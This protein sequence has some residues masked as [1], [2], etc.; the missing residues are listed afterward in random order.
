MI[1]PQPQKQPTEP[2]AAQS[3]TS[4]WSDFDLYLFGQGKD[5]HVYEKFGAHARLVDGVAGVNFSVWAPHARSV[6]V[7]G[8]FNSWDRTANSMWRRHNDLGVWECFI[9]GLRMGEVYKYF[10]TSSLNDYQVEKADP[11]AFAAERPPRTASI[12]Y[13]IHQHQWQDQDWMQ[14]RPQY[15][16]LPTPVAIYELHAGSWRHILDE[17]GSRPMTYRELA[18]ALAPY[19]KEMGFTHVELMPI[20]EYPYDPSWG[21]Q[22]TGYF[23][24]TS[25][26][27]APE[28]FQYFVD[29]LHQQGIGVILDWVPAHFPKDQYG[30]G[31]FDGTHLYEYADPRKGEHKEWG[32]YVFDYGRSEVCNFL[33]ASAVFWLREYHIDGLR[34][35][36]VASML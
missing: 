3:A 6:A 20:T 15:N 4:L 19:I 31:Y 18:Q 8:N 34:V 9:P 25:R 13:D 2:T 33:I 10:I 32:T 30:L 22:V 12:V 1:G 14:A 17:N 24:P 11:Y 36:A 27:G 7:I 28:D 23:A 35:D 29:Y 5:Y 16:P 21:Y 26:Y